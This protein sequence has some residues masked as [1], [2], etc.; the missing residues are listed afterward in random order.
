[1]PSEAAH[2]AID[3]DQLEEIA[4]HG[5]RGLEEAR[6][7]TWLLRAAAGFTGRANSALVLGTPPVT[8]T[9]WLTDV[10]SWYVQRG[11]PPKVQVPLPSG[12]QIEEVLAQAG[13]RP[14]DHVRVLTGDI[15]EV[16]ALAESHRST[17]GDLA[18]RHDTEPDDAW[19]AAYKYRGAALPA[20][21][22]EVLE[23]A[24]VDTQ[25]SFSS[26]RT[27]ASP[28][29]G[30]VLA[31]ARG[32][33]SRGWL[34]ITAVTVAESHRRRGLGT[35]L[36]AQLARWGADRGGRAIYLQ[37]ASD[38]TGA[39][40]LYERLGFHHHHDYRYHVGPAPEV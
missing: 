23:R 27:S 32:A 33:L 37:V 19:L 1:M 36:M 30:K 24:G 20:H 21:A 28:D 9:G 4:A 29:A 8:E 15:Q 31:V 2:V 13:W 40:E 25:L 18:I 35:H 34:G 7:G 38:N 10:V 39:L 6:L 17:P 3:V 16:Q 14:H 5:W 26:V 22:R 12:V 11:L